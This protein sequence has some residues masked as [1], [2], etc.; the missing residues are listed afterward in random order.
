MK[1]IWTVPAQRDFGRIDEFHAAHD[2]EFARRAGLLALQSGRFLA[3]HPYAGADIGGGV[4]KWHV[5]RT[6]Y[7]LLY[8]VADDTV[9]IL[10]VRHVREDWRGQTE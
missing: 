9:Q 4:R 6:S 7:V 1:V 8:R 2:P 5:A 3:D 10:R